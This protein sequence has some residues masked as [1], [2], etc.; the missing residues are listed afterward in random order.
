MRFV[1]DFKE[2]SKIF[3]DLHG[4]FTDLVILRTF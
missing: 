3:K 1:T 4:H 2:F